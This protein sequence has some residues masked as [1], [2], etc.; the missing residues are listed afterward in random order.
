MSIQVPFVGGPHDGHIHDIFTLW[1]GTEHA[2]PEVLEMPDD[3]SAP[4]A[5]DPATTV[6]VLHQVEGGFEYRPQEIPPEPA[7]D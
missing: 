6:Y 5:I 2:P 3:E 1:N 4:S 7:S